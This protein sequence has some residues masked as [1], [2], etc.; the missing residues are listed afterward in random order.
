MATRLRDLTDEELKAGLSC[1]LPV[2]YGTDV[3]TQLAEQAESEN[4]RGGAS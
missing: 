1:T 2:G 4:A 3:R